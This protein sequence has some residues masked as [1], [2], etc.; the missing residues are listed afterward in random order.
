MKKK[1]GKKFE[2]LPG[3]LF[4]RITP[5]KTRL[6][7]TIMPVH[8]IIKQFKGKQLEI[9]ADISMN[10]R[11]WIGI[12]RTSCLTKAFGPRILDSTKKGFASR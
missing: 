3:Q 12:G 11:K 9:G 7:Y 8:I 4:P 10:L 2:R 6:H 1:F 5:D